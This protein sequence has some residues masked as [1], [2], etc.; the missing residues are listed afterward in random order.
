MEHFGI[1][2]GIKDFYVWDQQEKSPHCESGNHQ[3]PQKSEDSGTNYLEV[4]EGV[5]VENLMFIESGN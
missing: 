3:K 2:K 1:Q 4:K 5:K